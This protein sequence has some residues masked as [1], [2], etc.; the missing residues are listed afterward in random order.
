M[1]R[2]FLILSL[3]TVLGSWSAVAQEVPWADRI[4][5]NI[6][7]A[8]RIVFAIDTSG[9]IKAAERL[10]FEKTLVSRLVR[11][12]ID[13]GRNPMVEVL[14][15]D[16]DIGVIVKLAPLDAVKDNIISA[17]NGIQDTENL[18]WINGA[19][20]YACSI[21]QPVH[22]NGALVL[23]TDGLPTTAE[24]NGSR[25]DDTAR[26]KT[27]VAA[28]NF[29]TNC[30]KFI[31][32]GT[33]V[34]KEAEEF[35][36]EIA[37]PGAFVYVSSAP[38][39]LRVVFPWPIYADPAVGSDYSGSAALVNLYDSLVY[40]TREGDVKPHVAEWWEA[41]SDGL[42]WTFYLKPGVR[43]HDLS[44]L[45]AEDV[46]FSMD[47]LLSIGEG[48]AHL[49]RDLVESTEVIDDYTVR[50]HLA[51]SFGPFPTNLVR[52]Y[53]LNKD[54]VMANFEDGPYAD[55]GDY[56]KKFLLT[57]DAGSGAYAIKKFAV[58]E[59]VLMERFPDYWGEIDPRAPNLVKF[60]ATPEAMNVRT[61]MA[62]QELEI[63]DH[64]KTEV[65]C[66]TLDAIEGV[67][68]AKFSTGEVFF[69]MMHTKKPPTDDIHFRK[70]MA[71]AFDY[72][73]TAWLFDS[74]ISHGPVAAGFP[75]W[76]PNVFTYTYDPEKAI[77]HL[78][79]SKYSDQLDDY[80]V[81]IHCVHE[82]P[83]EEK[84]AL[85][86]QANMAEIGIKVNVVSRPWVAVVDEMADI[87]TSPNIV[88]I[89]VT[90]HYPEAG[91][92]LESRYHSNSAPTWEQNEWLLDSY[93]D[94]T[95][96]DATATVDREERFAKYRELQDYI[97]ELCPSLF[98][99]DQVEKHAYQTYIDW[100]A[101][102]GE[103]IQVIGYNMDARFIKV[104]RH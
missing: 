58:E 80:P 63:S 44:E 55:F 37:S 2:L 31:V 89:Y 70:A 68:I 32:I 88:T 99:F 98:V 65:D 61:M 21:T 42:T 30:S 41:S 53:I 81:E 3:I 9:S 59:Y 86:F 85:L 36:R 82:V 84:L 7:D 96:K 56:G 91:S 20:D 34:S 52:L 33:D 40:P 27:R 5:G 64:C 66:A 78:H 19:I 23:S 10:S 45:T 102:R 100:P 15:F 73:A 25:D 101:A 38:K 103:V 95:I 62:N 35:L 51:R 11:M 14:A 87:E 26:D 4:F 76:N 69:Y 46:K 22:P 104:L 54:V 75:G 94:E 48:Y 50:F 90:P 16:S 71:Y 13:S 60:I 24:R 79:Q 29:K 28:E 74:P 47:R 93:F 17:I 67:D 6:E 57:N 49:F 8:E 92:M 1:A 72:E 83:S 43:F 18:T 12:L 39:V 97:V 77:E